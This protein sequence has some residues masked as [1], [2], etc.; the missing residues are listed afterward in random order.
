MLYRDTDFSLCSFGGLF[1]LL[2]ERRNVGGMGNDG[3][4]QEK[5]AS[6]TD[7]SLHVAI[8]APLHG[9]GASTI[10]ACRRSANPP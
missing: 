2:L 8:V 10:A 3:E 4:D 1:D 7:T 6:K 9:S 5:S